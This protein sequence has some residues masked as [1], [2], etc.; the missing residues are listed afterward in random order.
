MTIF[1]AFCIEER[2]GAF[3]VVNVD[4]LF[5]YKAFDKQYADNSDG[6]GPP[7]SPFLMCYLVCKQ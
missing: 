5:Y 3:H 2:S 4:S 6:F 1:S 7:L